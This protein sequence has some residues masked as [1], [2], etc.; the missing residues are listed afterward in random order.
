MNTESAAQLMT[1]LREMAESIARHGDDV[2]GKIA[3]AVSD[4][5]GRL[6]AARDGF[7]S[8]VKAVA[9]G[10]AAGARQ[11]LP[12]KEESILR[13]A[14]EGLADGLA[15]SAHAVQLAL[16]ESS[17]GGARFA[18]D[19]L[20]KIAQDFR[21]VGE[22]FVNV[23]TDAARQLRSHVSGQAQA[24]ADHAARTFQSVRPALESALAAAAREPVALAGD[25]LKAGAAA[26]RQAA[27]A[28]FAELGRRLQGGDAPRP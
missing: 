1:R 8:L 2:R 14:V 17:A 5:S 25:S 28:L 26:A 9:E 22:I 23:V 3:Q 6:G 15:K 10:A 19:D 24:A 16:E 7:T 20:Q 11:A 18:K 4:A 21:G 13:S 12:D 27:G